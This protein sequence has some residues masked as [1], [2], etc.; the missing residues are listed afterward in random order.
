MS[1]I[2]K[3]RTITKNN[4]NEYL[5]KDELASDIENSINDFTLNSIPEPSLIDVLFESIYDQKSKEI[6]EYFK[7]NKKYL[8]ESIQSKQLDPKKLAD[9]KAEELNPEKYSK[10]ITK[11]SYSKYKTN[12]GSN[13]FTCPKCKKS[14]CEVSQKQTRSGDEPPTT[15]VKCLVCNNV[16]KF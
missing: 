8:L 5:N 14:E 7:T 12:K 2:N 11:K 15:F 6:L 13:L 4:L 3:L 16:M 9:C 10:I 1:D